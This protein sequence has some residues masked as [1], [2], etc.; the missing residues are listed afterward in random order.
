MSLLKT[1]GVMMP[2]FLLKFIQDHFD[3]VYPRNIV[4]MINTFD[5]FYKLDLIPKFAIDSKKYDGSFRK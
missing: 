1:R 2:Y 3:L 4:R 5:V